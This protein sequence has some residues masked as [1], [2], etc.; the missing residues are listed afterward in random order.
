MKCRID[1][2]MDKEKCGRLAM[3]ELAEIMTRLTAQVLRAGIL[4]PITITNGTGVRVAELRIEQ[5]G[6]GRKS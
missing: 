2:A 6:G 5:E 4:M 3:I 1:L